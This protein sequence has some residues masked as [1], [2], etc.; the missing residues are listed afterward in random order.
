MSLCEPDD[1]DQERRRRRFAALASQLS[2]LA[3]DTSVEE[4]A[5]ATRRKPDAVR[6]R[7]AAMY[8]THVAFDLSL[9]Q[10]AAAFGRDRTTVSFACARIEEWRDD[11]AFDA[12]LAALEDCLRLAPGAAA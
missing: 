6:A 2:A 11:P 10:V 12:R 4:M 3:F 5:R 8:L 9:S 1:Y 7:H